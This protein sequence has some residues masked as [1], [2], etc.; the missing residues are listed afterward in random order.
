MRSFDRRDH[1]GGAPV[2]A[3][4]SPRMERE[5]PGAECEDAAAPFV[6]RPLFIDCAGERLVGVLALPREPARVGVVVIVGGPQYRAGSHRQFVQLSRRLANA[7]F[8]TLRFDYRGMGDSTGAPRTFEECGPDIAAAVDAMRANCEGVEQIVLWGLC[9]AA[10]A[11]LDYWH[12]ARDPRVAAMALLNPWVRSEATL[13][14]AHVKHYYVQRLLSKE[15]WA[16]LV[17]GGS[18]PSKRFARS[19]ATSCARSLVRKADRTAPVNPSRTGWP[20]AL[21]AFP[22]PVLLILSGDDL[23]AK[24]FLEYAQSGPGWQGLLAR[25]GLERLRSARRGSH[26]LERG[27]AAKSRRARCRGSMPSPR[28]DRDEKGADDRV[29]LS[30]ARREQRNPA[31]A[32]LCA[33][34]AGARVGAD[35]AD[36][37]SSR[38]R[39]HERRSFG[40]GP[41]RSRRQA[42]FRARH[43]APAL[44]RRALSRMARA[45]RPLDDVAFRRRER[46]SRPHPAACAGCPVVDLSDRHRSRHRASARAPQQ[47]PVDRG[48]SRSDGAGRVSRGSRH[49][50]KLQGNR[51]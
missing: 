10:S 9:D 18:H 48:F 35:R 49:L 20:P 15:F 2:A 40:R 8:P 23:T 43:R 34:T 12:S 45:P 3:M 14:K 6:E 51:D 11:A 19:P 39:T 38:V 46:R 31:D 7:G 1:G 37:R 50:A 36:G 13:A 33:A 4:T 47:A 17:S 44:V 22:G 28:A 26:V 27:A 30:A 16:K 25:S 32:A 21:R 24:E 42:R 41:R 29:P 5:L